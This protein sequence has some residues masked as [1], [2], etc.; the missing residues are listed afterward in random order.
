MEPVDVPAMTYVHK[1]NERG[2]LHTAAV[3]VALTPRQHRALRTYSGA[4]ESS[5]SAFVRALVIQSIPPQYWEHEEPP[6]GQM[7]LGETE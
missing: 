1:R 5:M 4:V 6:P 2:P 3:S 7:R